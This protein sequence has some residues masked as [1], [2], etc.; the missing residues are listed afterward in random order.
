MCCS[1]YQ[2]C[3]D[4]R[5]YMRQEEMADLGPDLFVLIGC[6]KAEKYSVLH[7]KKR[8]LKDSG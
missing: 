4:L 6:F 5:V 1:L 8:L 2:R 7:R 3:C